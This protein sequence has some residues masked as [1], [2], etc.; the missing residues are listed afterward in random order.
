[1]TEILSLLG[2]LI[3]EYG[4]FLTLFSLVTLSLVRSRDAQTRQQNMVTAQFERQ[5]ERI[6][7]LQV[8]CDN[9]RDQINQLRGQMESERRLCK[10]EISQLQTQ[11]N[12]M[13]GGIS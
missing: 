5:A 3:R 12:M 9:Q 1:M 13:T 10:E 11:I 7:A 8:V 4:L 6:N 2:Q